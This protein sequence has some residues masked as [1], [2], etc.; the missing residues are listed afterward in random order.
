MRPPPKI[1]P[2]DAAAPPTFNSTMVR[3]VGVVVSPVSKSAVP[4]PPRARAMSGSVS[5][6]L[7]GA[8]DSLTGAELELD[9]DSLWNWPGTDGAVVGAPVITAAGTGAGGAGADVLSNFGAASP[10]SGSGPKNAG[11]GD[12]AAPVMAG[13]L[14][15]GSVPLYP[16]T[17]FS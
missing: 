4:Q 10:A 9:F 1:S 8:D 17:G 6:P 16:T 2:S 13:A 12:G 7:G 15:A 5:T 3:G 11:T 14:L